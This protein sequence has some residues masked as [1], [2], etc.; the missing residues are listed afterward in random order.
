M[1]LQ[2]NCYQQ[3][4]LQHYSLDKKALFYSA[5]FS[6]ATQLFSTPGAG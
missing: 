3:N 6:P 1:I 2:R 4:R 5:F